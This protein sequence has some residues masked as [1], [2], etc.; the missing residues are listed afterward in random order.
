MRRDP[1]SSARSLEHR[2]FLTPARALIAICCLAVLWFAMLLEHSG[3]ADRALFTYLHASGDSSIVPVARAVA[4][5]GSWAG[6]EVA[7]CAGAG[8]LL[9]GQ[10]RPWL[11]FLLVATAYAGHLL[12]DFQQ[13]H[14]DLPRPDPALWLAHVDTSSFPSG[15]AAQSMLVYLTIALMLTRAANEYRWLVALALLLSLLLGLSRIA[16]GVHWPSDVIAGWS[17]GAAWAVLSYSA[18]IALE[19]VMHSR[20]ASVGPH[21][22]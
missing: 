15:H 7:L 4:P 1:N 3:S 14:L 5:L 22:G 8:L 17:F 19:K 6:L 16:L 10:R 12:F 13:L 11:A 21:P 2:P 18:A 20:P 9:L